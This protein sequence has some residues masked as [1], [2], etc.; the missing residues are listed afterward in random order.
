MEVLGA[1]KKIKIFVSSNH[2][3]FVPTDETDQNGFSYRC[4]ANN[5]RHIYPGY[6][7]I[8][9]PSS[10]RKHGIALGTYGCA[11]EENELIADRNEKL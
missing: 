5:R 6:G 8:S 10:F 2:I 7:E 3:K 1:T 4:E 11:V 9:M